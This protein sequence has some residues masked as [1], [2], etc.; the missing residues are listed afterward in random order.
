MLFYTLISS[1]IPADDESLGQKDLF[2]EE[3]N[4]MKTLGK[5][6]NIVNLIGCVT[7]SEPLQLILEYVPYGNL[8]DW[9]RKRRPAAPETIEN[10]TNYANLTDVIVDVIQPRSRKSNVDADSDNSDDSS[11]STSGGAGKEVAGPANDHVTNE[12][13]LCIAWQVAGAMV[14]IEPFISQST[15]IWLRTP[16]WW[17]TINIVINVHKRVRSCDATG[18]PLCA[19]NRYWSRF[20]FNMQDYLVT[21][22]LVHRDLAARNILVG[23]NDVMKIT[24]FGM[25]RLLY[26][27]VYQTQTKKKMP[28][29]WM[30]PETLRDL[31]FT[32]QSDV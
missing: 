11:S 3:I 18:L 24:D 1:I 30:A 16:F 25:T 12:Q 8:L 6:R 32:T 27:E 4:A 5:H 2:R 7:L 21:K 22:G 15:F 26:E 28:I 13:M 10:E 20:L 31:V 17:P 19:E 9:L 14:C 29:K 23:D